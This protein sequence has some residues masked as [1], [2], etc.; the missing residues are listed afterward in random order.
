MGSR[1]FCVLLIP[2]V[3]LKKQFIVVAEIVHHEAFKLY[4]L[5]P[6][7]FFC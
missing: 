2:L 7:T 4:L 5:Y 3:F 1:F 6:K